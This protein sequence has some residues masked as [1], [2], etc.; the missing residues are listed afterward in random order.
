MLNFYVKGF[1][2]KIY[3]KVLRVSIFPNHVMDSFHGL[4]DDS[5]LSKMLYSTIPPHLMTFYVLV[6]CSLLCPIPV[7]ELVHFGMIQYLQSF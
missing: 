1:M 5:Y 7:F 2:L 6:F 3:V 4:Y